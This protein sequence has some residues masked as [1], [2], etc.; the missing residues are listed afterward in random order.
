MDRRED[1]GS[2][3]CLL[4][5]LLL[6]D[7]VVVSSVNVVLATSRHGLRCRR[8]CGHGDG[9]VAGDDNVLF[10]CRSGDGSQWPRR[11]NRMRRRWRIMMMLMLKIATSTSSERWRYPCARTAVRRLEMWLV[12]RRANETVTMLVVRGFEMARRWRRGSGLLH[13]VRTTF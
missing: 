4:R 9:N 5:L 11:R 8:C 10:G 6:T 12:R 3:G 1:T 13:I 2:K 7:G